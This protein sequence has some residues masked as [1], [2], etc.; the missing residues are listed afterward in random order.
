MDTM[1]PYKYTFALAFIFIPFLWWLFRLM[2]KRGQ[3]TENLFVLLAAG[4]SWFTVLTLFRAIWTTTEFK[5][6]SFIFFLIF[7][8]P[9]IFVF[10]RI[11]RKIFQ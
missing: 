6:A 4:Y 3:L 5:A 8:F 7:W 11:Y 2:R 9:S 1:L 10:R